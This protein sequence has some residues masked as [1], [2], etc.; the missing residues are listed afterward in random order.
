MYKI[1]KAEERNLLCNSEKKNCIDIIGKEVNMK[2]SE[3][4]GRAI[5]MIDDSV[6]S[7]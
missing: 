1:T 6:D 4:Y 5:F 2:K 7:Y 3:S